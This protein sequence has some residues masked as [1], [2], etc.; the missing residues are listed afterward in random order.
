MAD[1]QDWREFTIG[2]G[3]NKNKNPQPS[4]PKPVIQD[5]EDPPKFR[6]FDKQLLVDLANARTAKNLTRDQVAKQFMLKSSDINDLENGKLD[7]N[8]KF[9]KS[10]YV[11]IMRK[12]GV[13]INLSD[14]I[15]M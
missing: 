3:K 15:K 10:L 6:P 2:N 4:N 7:F 1:C 9:A 5:D 12:L 11:T 8:S 14:L 13:K